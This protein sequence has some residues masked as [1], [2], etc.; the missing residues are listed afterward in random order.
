MRS[1]KKLIAGF[2]LITTLSLT[3]TEP[4]T[5]GQIINVVMHQNEYEIITDKNPDTSYTI[6]HDVITP[7]QDGYL[8]TIIAKRIGEYTLLGLPLYH[9]VLTITETHAGQSYTRTVNARIVHENTSF[10]LAAILIL[11]LGGIVYKIAKKTQ[12][13]YAAS[14]HA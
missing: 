1:F 13:S 12:A 8:R 6:E 10:A 9:Y 2:V 11:G 4:Y 7:T 14:L 3:A 5:K